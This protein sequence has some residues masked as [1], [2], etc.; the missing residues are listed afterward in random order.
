[1]D[2]A[3]Q[4]GFRTGL[5]AGA[6]LAATSFLLAVTF[7]VLAR[8][9]GWG[10]LAPVVCSFVV[11]SGSAQFA[12]LATLSSGGGALAAVT[13]AALVNIRYVPMGIAVARDLRGRRLRR[14]FEGQAVVDGSWAAAHLGGGRFDRPLLLGA[15]AVQWPA[16]VAG[17]ALGAMA[18]PVAGF[19][20]PLG[21]DALTPAL[22]AVLL[23]D[24]VKR[25]HEGRLAAALGAGVAGV[26]IAFVPAGPALIGG[27][28]AAGLAALR[29]PRAAVAARA[30]EV[31][32]T[33][34]EAVR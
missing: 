13:A 16:W 23:L 30:D 17:T 15:T 19:L 21:L 12:M 20:H 7:G 2:Q 1:M 29:R 10:E 22:F 27:A 6:A 18:T 25:G 26:L 9:Q 8:A 4:D 32:R 24:E 5:R 3:S 33:G 34:E 11:F 28:G 31:A 14:A